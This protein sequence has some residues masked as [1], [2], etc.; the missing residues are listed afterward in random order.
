MRRQYTVAE[1]WYPEVGPV[2]YI[3]MVTDQDKIK[4]GIK[5]DAGQIICTRIL[6]L[7]DCT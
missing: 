1:S 3:Y 2:P 4:R 6:R 5:V 7:R